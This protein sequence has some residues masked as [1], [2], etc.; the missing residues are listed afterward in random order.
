MAYTPENNPYIPGDPYSYDLKWVVDEID[1]WKTSED[2][3]AE[4]TAQA[5]R[6][7]EEADRAE[8]KANDAASSASDAHDSELAARDYADNIAD[9]VSGLVTTW[10]A[11]NITQPTTPAIDTSLTVAGAAADAKAAGDRID[12]NTDFLD[13][14]F[15]F[16]NL[17]DSAVVSDAGGGYKFRKFAVKEGET[18]FY[19]VLANGNNLAWIQVY[20]TS[21]VQIGTLSDISG[22]SSW[23][24]TFVCPAGVGYIRIM[25]DP[26]DAYANTMFFG[27]PDYYSS[28]QAGKDYVL[29]NKVLVPLE[30]DL[31]PVGIGTDYPTLTAGFAAARAMDLGVIITPGVYDLN[32]EGIDITDNGLIAPKKVYGYG[33]TLTMTFPI[34]TTNDPAA[35]AINMPQAESCEIYGLR[36]ECTNA[37]Y[38]IHDEMYS[39]ADYYHH[40]FKDLILIHNCDTGTSGLWVAPRT[41]GGGLGNSGLIEIE[42]ILSKSVAYE[43]INYHSNGSGTQT[44][45]CTVFIKDSMI[46]KGC[47]AT[48]IGTDTS[49]MNRVLVTSCLFGKN[50]PD[51]TGYNILKSSWNNTVI[52]VADFDLL[53]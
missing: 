27:N 34:Y 48:D 51:N 7:K 19:N 43:D 3:V 29:T 44:G 14:T 16:C 37:R 32:A 33:A 21:N 40:V 49:F 31:L 23:N 8:E 53:F 35:S 25:A 50:V 47:S 10:L 2:A 9:P 20:D 30:K 5:D 28:W 39:F 18:Y 17:I 11:D 4:S 6:A 22:T 1:K 26:T 45:E 15:D 41:I 24:T 36:I 52:P 38:C 46:R 12:A 13:K 42:N